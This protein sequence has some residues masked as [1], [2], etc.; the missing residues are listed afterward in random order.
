MRQE[1][2]KKT[3]FNSIYVYITSRTTYYNYNRQAVKT[4]EEE[5]DNSGGSNGS[6]GNGSGN[7]SNGN[8]SDH[9]HEESRYSVRFE[10]TRQVRE[11]RGSELVGPGF[12]SVTSS[13]LRAGQIVY[14]TH[15]NREVQ[16]AVLH[17]HRPNIDQ[18]IIQIL[19]RDR[20]LISGGEEEGGGKATMAAS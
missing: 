19:V 12:A 3:C 15:A 11:F 6:S 5:D 2:R 4:C 14:V 10:S 20:W 1:E 9:H 17:H 18:V 8:G 16:G 13:K 7:G